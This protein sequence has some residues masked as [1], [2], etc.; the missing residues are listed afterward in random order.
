M[1][2]TPVLFGPTQRPLV[3]NRLHQAPVSLDVAIVLL[4]RVG[5]TFIDY[6]DS[7]RTAFTSRIPLRLQA[8]HSLS[9]RSRRVK[10]ATS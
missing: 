9:I 7:R 3:A 6:V 5:P 10:S 8:I 2:A 1:H 4:N